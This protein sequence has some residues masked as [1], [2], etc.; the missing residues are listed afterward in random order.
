MGT[1]KYMYIVW[2]TDLA[3]SYNS[4]ERPKE[5]GFYSFFFKQIYEGLGYMQRAISGESCGILKTATQRD[6]LIWKLDKSS[7]YSM[8]KV[9][10]L[11][12]YDHLPM[13]A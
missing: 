9:T 11:A 2:L 5:T 13:S 1:E 6:L 12:L 8:I 10:W 7:L 4:Q 3:W